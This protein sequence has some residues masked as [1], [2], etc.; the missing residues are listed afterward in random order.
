MNRDYA[1][2]G[3]AADARLE[4]VAV[5][6]GLYFGREHDALLHRPGLVVGGEDEPIES[7]HEFLE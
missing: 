6:H 5:R 4:D 3:R 2:R 7:W 1:P